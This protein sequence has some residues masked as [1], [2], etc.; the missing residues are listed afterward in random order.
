MN[1]Q[2]ERQHAGDQ[3]RAGVAE[4]LQRLLADQAPLTRRTLSVV[5]ARH[6]A[7]SRASDASTSPMKASS[8]V[9]SGGLVGAGRVLQSSGEPLGDHPALVDQRDPV[10]VLGLVQEVRRDEHRHAPLDHAR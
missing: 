8:S 5:G 7:S 10:A 6:A 1:E 2:Q 9:G 4:D 3:E